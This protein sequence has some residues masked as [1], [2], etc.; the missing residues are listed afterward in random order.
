MEGRN[1]D[2]TE[3]KRRFIKDKRQKKTTQVRRAKEQKTPLRL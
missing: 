1:Y 2:M 3:N